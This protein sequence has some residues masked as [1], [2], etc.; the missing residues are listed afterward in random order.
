L[1]FKET[2]IHCPIHR[3]GQ[4]RCRRLVLRATTL[5]EAI[6]SDFGYNMN[7]VPLLCDNESAIRLANN[8]I[9][10]NN[11]KHIDI[12]HNFLRNYQ[13][14][15]DIDVCHISTDHQLAYTF[16]KPL[17]EQRFCKLHSELNV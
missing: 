9:E 1:E 12:R 13:Q 4:V 3:K 8:P 11:T 6:P 16:T 10:H 14:K 15:G 5:D 17:D 7:K 2:N